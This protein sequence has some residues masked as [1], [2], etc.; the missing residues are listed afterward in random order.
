MKWVYSVCVAQNK[1]L[2]RVSDT[3]DP[4]LGNCS[5]PHPKVGQGKTVSFL[6][7]EGILRNWLQELA[8][9][10]L[11]QQQPVTWNDKWMVWGIWLHSHLSLWL[12]GICTALLGSWEIRSLLRERLASGARVSDSRHQ[13]PWDRWRRPGKLSLGSG[14]CYLLFTIIV[15][16]SCL[17][18]FEIIHNKQKQRGL[19]HHLPQHLLLAHQG[20]PN[21]DLPASHPPPPERQCWEQ[22]LARKPA[23]LKLFMVLRANKSKARPASPA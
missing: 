19:S 21:P 1:T 4:L 23:P 5:Q 2:G 14:L 22:T 17:Y 6:K 9:R 15:S 13:P 20:C 16:V 8:H 10:N 7:K 18:L 12:S 11:A 3:V